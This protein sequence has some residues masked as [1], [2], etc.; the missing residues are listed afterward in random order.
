MACGAEIAAGWVTRS[1][2]AECRHGLIRML[3]ASTFRTIVS[4]GLPAGAVLGTCT[5]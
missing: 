3:T 1:S 5:T 4:N 2:L